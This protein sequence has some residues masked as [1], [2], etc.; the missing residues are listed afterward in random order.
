MDSSEISTVFYL[1]AFPLLDLMVQ[2][3]SYCSRLCLPISND[4][5]KGEY[6]NLVVR[7]NYDNQSKSQINPDKRSPANSGLRIQDKLHR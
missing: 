5:E 3:L 4:M 6:S 7:K 2:M 1:T